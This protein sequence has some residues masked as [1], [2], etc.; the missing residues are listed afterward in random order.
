MVRSSLPFSSPLM[1]TD[2]PMF[3]M[4]FS[5]EWLVSGRGLTPAVAGVGGCG[6]AGCPL[7]GRTASSRFHMYTSACPLSQGAYDQSR[8]G[9]CRSESPLSIE[10]VRYVV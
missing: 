8:G 1:T 2:F 3:T 6:A 10:G 5:M 4:S 7:A 9:E